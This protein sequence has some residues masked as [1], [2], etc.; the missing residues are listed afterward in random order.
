MLSPSPGHGGLHRP[1]ADIAASAAELGRSRARALGQAWNFGSNSEGS[2][3]RV[4]AV[5]GRSVTQETPS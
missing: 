2:E 4:N 3:H 5:D 1:G